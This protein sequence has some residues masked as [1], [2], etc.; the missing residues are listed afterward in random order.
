VGYSAQDLEAQRH[1][2]E[3]KLNLFARW[4]RQNEEHQADLTGL[5]ARRGGARGGKEDPEGEALDLLLSLYQRLED[6]AR[7]RRR[8]ST[9]PHVRNGATAS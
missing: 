5:L 2:V 8:F 9:D 6:Q 3:E 7:Q 1:L 4:A